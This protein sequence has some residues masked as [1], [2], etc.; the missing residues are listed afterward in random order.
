MPSIYLDHAATTPLDGRVF[1]TIAAHLAVYGNPSSMHTRGRE[2]AEAL[3]RARS[4]VARVFGAEESNEI[5]FTGSGTEADNLAVLGIARANKNK[6]NHIIVSAI[7]HKA[8]LA[9]AEALKSEGF[10]ITHIPVDESGVVHPQDVVEALRADT[11][12]VSIMYANNEIGTI[13]PIRD[14][15]RAIRE[16]KKN[17]APLPFFHTDACQAAPFLPLDVSR[18][19]VDAMSVSASKVYGPKGVGTLYLRHGAPLLPVIHGGG[20]E[21]GL[22]GGTEQVALIAGFAEALAIA[23]EKKEKECARL[24]SL[25]DY[26]IDELKTRLPQAVLTGS[27][28]ARLPNNV[29][30]CVPNIEGESLVLLLDAKGVYASTG[31]AC[32][33]H[34]L[35][36]SHVLRALGISH[37]A[38]HGSVRFTLGRDTSK[39]DI[40]YT[41]DAF[42]DAVLFL[43]K[44]TALTTS[45]YQQQRV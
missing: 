23:E 41:M 18:L 12:L 29:H 20:Q 40:D 13:Q 24:S 30:V 27:R 15:V 42:S 35:L 39:E 17:N 22:R 7:E 44:A 1:E 6:G 28:V 31:S 25:R 10:E 26:F 16:A 19:G 45:R 9:S 21:R 34:D 43:E 3:S 33:A 36:P 11:I 38:I 2:A 4:A 8:V 14:I 5:I 32:S 37:E